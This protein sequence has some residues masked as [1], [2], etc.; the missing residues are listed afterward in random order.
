MKLCSAA[1]SWLDGVDIELESAPSPQNP[2]TDAVRDNVNK[3]VRLPIAPSWYDEHSS[4][5]W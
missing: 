5:L 4:E 1:P 2:A 3:S